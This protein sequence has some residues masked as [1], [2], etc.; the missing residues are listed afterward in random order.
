MNK[1]EILIKDFSKSWDYLNKW[2]GNEIKEYLRKIK[3]Y[4]SKFNE[5]S[6][7]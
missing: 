1:I 7:S 3:Y 6:I 2:Y 5:N 4:L